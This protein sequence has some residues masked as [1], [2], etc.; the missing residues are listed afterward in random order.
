MNPIVIYFTV[1]LGKRVK[2]LKKNE[3]IAFEHF[4]QALTETLDGIQQ[5]RASNREH[6]YIAAVIDKARGIKTHSAAFAWKNDHR[7][8]S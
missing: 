3:N 2:E 5:I 8:Y 7:C 1:V 4:Q 6:H